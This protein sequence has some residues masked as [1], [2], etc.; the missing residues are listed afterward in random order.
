MPRPS[1]PLALRLCLALV[2]MF[3][4]VVPSKS[5]AEWQAE[6][7][8]E[9]RHRWDVLDERHRLDWRNRMDLFR[10]ALG[11]LPDAAWLRRQFTA[12]ADIVHDLR[13][14]GRMLWK[15]PVFMLSAVLILALGIGGTVSI[16]TLLDTLLFRPLPYAD[17]DR[18]LTVWTR[19][20]ARP[21][22]RADVAPAD[23]LDWRER[24]RSFSAIAAAVPY[25]RDYTAGGDPEVL[26]GAQVTEGF[27][28]AIG[29]QPTMGRGF[30]PEEHVKGA[31][32]VV[33]ITYGLWQSRFAG[34]P[35]IINRAISLDG[36]P[37]TVVGV[38]PKVFAPQL[39]PPARRADAL[40]A[41]DHSGPREADALQRVVERRRAPQARRHARGSAARDG[42]D[43]D[44]SR[45]AVS[46][47]E[48]VDE[49]CARAD[50]RTPDG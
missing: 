45:A 47:V 50:A 4:A 38:L 39:L 30:L 17:A 3:S 49:R 48:R 46:A 26:F 36:E 42:H 44:R 16:V 1:D 21:S 28:D 43:R 32:N 13:H 24:S 7:E 18:V 20:A 6:W 15:S 14:G 22:E 2:R 5:R 37:W 33:V 11:A 35:G 25:S 10:R 27:W 40:D 8:A 41:E 9:V 29:M 34:D 19:H 23:F 31:R 12:D